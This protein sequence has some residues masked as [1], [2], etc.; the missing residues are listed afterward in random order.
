MV[1]RSNFVVQAAAWRELA[2]RARRLA[3]GLINEA[4]RAPLLDYSKE[5]DEKAARLESEAHS[6][7]EAPPAAS[8]SEADPKTRS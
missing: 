8:T 5:L 7:Q 6:R 4:D 2:N 1:D 3:A